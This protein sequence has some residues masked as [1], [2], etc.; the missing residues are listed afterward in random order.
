VDL[1]QLEHQRLEF[2]RT[3]V[4]EKRKN[5]LL[6]LA[7]EKCGTNQRVLTRFGVLGESLADGLVASSL[8]KAVA[9]D[10]E[11]PVDLST[12]GGKEL[13]VIPFL[14]RLVDLLHTAGRELMPLKSCNE[15]EVV[16]G[17]LDPE[18]VRT[19]G[20][21]DEMDVRARLHAMLQ[22]NEPIGRRGLVE[23]EEF[24]RKDREVSGQVFS[25]RDEE[26]VVRLR[27]REGKAAPEDAAE[28][29]EI[30][31]RPIR[32]IVLRP[33]GGRLAPALIDPLQEDGAGLIVDLSGCEDP[34]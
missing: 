19:V 31:V 34:L 16:I 6:G 4:L 7:R 29:M 8:R 18:L 25:V 15:V 27:R 9:P 20:V 21:R 24:G 12:K 2:L 11:R 13:V 22:L 32:G 30:G 26:H 23:R 33:E 14:V 10:V 17:Q 5:H 1:E 3:P 28:Q